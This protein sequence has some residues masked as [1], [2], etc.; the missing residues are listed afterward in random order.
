[1]VYRHGVWPGKVEGW[2]TCGQLFANKNYFAVFYPMDSKAKAGDALRVF[3]QEYGVPE[4]LVHDGAKE[5]TGKKTEFQSQVSKHDIITRCSEPNLHNQSPA[6]GV[7]REVRRKWFRVMFRKRVPKIFWDY[8]I[9][10]VCETMSRTYLQ[11]QR[12]DGGVPLTKVTGE[13]VDISP[14]LEF[15]F[16]D[17]VWFRDNA[18]LGP[19]LPGS[20]LGIAKNIGG[21]MCYH[22]LHDNGQ[23]TARSTVWTPT[24]L[25]LQTDEIK[26]TFAAFD[27]SISRMLKNDEFPA[28]GD[29][30][31]P[32]DM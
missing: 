18:G 32:Q 29:K 11:N 23:I 14:Y 15:S 3:C 25:E 19:Q 7:V 1:V 31:D 4:R 13:T 24:Q 2:N 16:Y 20:W 26:Q 9:V 6:E 10:W 12:V 30:P 5:M 22:V 27:Q 28:V 8:G 21:M 17:R